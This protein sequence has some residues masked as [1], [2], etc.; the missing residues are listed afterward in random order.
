MVFVLTTVLYGQKLNFS[1]VDTPVET[2]LKKISEQT[3]YQFVYSDALSA[4]KSKMTVSVNDED[5]EVFFKRFFTQLEI[6]YKIDKTHVLLSS[7]EIVQAGR[8]GSSDTSEEGTLLGIVLNADGEP[9]VGATVFNQTK[10][11]GVAAGIDGKFS[12]R[13]NIGDK[14]VISSIGYKNQELTMGSQSNINIVMEEDSEILDEIVVVGYGTQKKSTM[15]GSVSTISATDI[16][17]RPV[18]SVGAVLYGASPGVM[19]TSS[20]GTPGDDPSIRIRGFGTI[21]S[22]SS[23]VYVVDGAIFDISLRTINPAD[24]E[25]ISILKDAAATAIYGSRGANGVIMITTKK[26]KSEKLSF[27]VNVL[28]G[29]NMRFVPEYNMVSAQEYY[30]LMYE[31]KRNSLYYNDNLNMDIATANRLA[32][33]GGNYRGNQYIS[34]LDDLGGINPFYGIDNNEIIDPVT[35]QLNPAATRLKWG[36][37]VDWYS[38]MSR[39]GS[40]TDL[41]VSAGGGTEKSDYYASLNYLNDNAWMQRSFTKRISVRANVNFKPTTWFKIGTNVSG[42][43]INSYNQS[44]SGDG[45]NNPFF[46]AR[47]IGSIYP[48]YIHDQVT[49]AYI[50]DANGDKI[51]DTGGQVI[52]GITYPNRPALGGN[53]NI[54]AELFADD[55]QYKRNSLQSRTYAEVMFLNDFKFTISANIGYSPYSGYNYS[56]NKIGVNAPAGS[57][58]RSNRVNSS[59]TYQQLLS[60]NKTFSDKHEIDMVVGHESY[61]TLTEQANVARRG[62]IMDGNIELSNFTEITQAITSKA[63]HRSE[64]YLMRTNYSYDRGRYSLECSFRRDGSS[65]FHRNV[66]WGNFWSTGASWNIAREKFMRDI[67][68][69]DNLK[70]RASYGING[71]LEGIDNYNWQDVYLLNHN[72]QNEAGYYQDPSAANRA[73]TWEKQ[74]QFSLALDYSFFKQRISGSIEYFDKRNDDLLFSVRQP[75]STGLTTQN[76]NIGALYNRGFEMEVSVDIIRRKDFAWNFGVSAATLKNKITRMPDDNPEI[77]SGTKKLMVGHSIYDFFLYDWYGVDPRDGYALYSLDPDATWSESTCRVMPNGD[78]VTTT[79]N[80]AARVY[81]GSAIPDVYGSL[82]TT[83]HYKEFSLVTRFGYQLGGKLNDAIYRSATYAGRYG[84]SMHQDMTRRWQKPGDVTDIPR[85][86]NTYAQVFNASSTRYL[87]S[88]NYL[89]LSSATLAYSFPDKIVEYLSVGELTLNVSG[90]NLFLLTK[91]KGMNPME[92]FSGTTSNSYT[93]SR[94]LTFGISLIL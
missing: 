57:S 4:I 74:A 47:S 17:K 34:I 92:S 88:S 75:S 68:W 69:M 30:Q 91:R 72:N 37:D 44:W 42:S 14:I 29:I 2:I 26:G 63:E 18:T 7:S 43:I 27:S 33:H 78:L 22:S 8:S 36:D 35:G 12:I 15:V 51:Y 82:R 70:I 21:N 84:Y 81:K 24:I 25:S 16:T 55:V 20:G 64:G 79:T 53:R 90:E 89:A 93:P 66:R 62:Q 40:R 71:N 52:D 19:A 10:Q 39:V 9:V 48:I 73:L 50:L 41:T 13:A 58:S 86:D 6:I 1:F 3:D 5:P 87:I 32:A 31:A 94:V 77:I 60:Y 83:F 54:V 28:R 56:S 59:Q 49:G 45:T 11:M 38:P 61:Q 65:K 85:M 76:Q 67:P 80:K 23:P 46:V